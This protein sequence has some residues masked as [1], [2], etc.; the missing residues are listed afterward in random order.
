MTLEHLQNLVKTN[1][2]K[3]ESRDQR[4]FD[5]LVEAARLNLTDAK[6]PKLSKQG[7]FKLAYSGAHGFAL[8]ALRWHGYRSDSRFI[9]F[10]CLQHTLKIKPEDWAVL[11]LCHKKR[12]LSEYEGV[13]D[14][15]DGLL[16]DLIRMTELL[17]EKI[18]QLS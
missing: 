6:I 9:V 4:E 14:V 13:L 17:Y 15:E 7:Q 18:K 12:N 2:L 10:Q 3:Q 16:K 8:A 11:S 5:G 1:Q